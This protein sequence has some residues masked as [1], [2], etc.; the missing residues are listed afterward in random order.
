MVDLG[1]AL[2]V[3]VT[4]AMV[5]GLLQVVVVSDPVPVSE[6]GVVHVGPV[7]T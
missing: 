6:G 2:A 3:S 5:H 7:H 4:F 1:D